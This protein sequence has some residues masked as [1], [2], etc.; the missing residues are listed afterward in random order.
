MSNDNYSAERSIANYRIN[1]A[2]EHLLGL[3]TGLVADGQLNDIE[4]KMLSLWIT[5][6]PE[7]ASEYPGSV[8]VKKITEVLVDGIITEE[9]RTHLLT[10]LLQ[11]ASADFSSTGSAD[12]EVVA[13]PIDDNVSPDFRNSTVCFTGNFLYGTKSD[14]LKLTEKFG[15]KCINSLTKKVNVLVIGTKVSPD[16]KHTTFGNKIKNAAEL[17]S[18]GHRIHIISE[19]RWLELLR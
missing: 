18:S 4:I 3:V 15:A 1:R 11:L 17:Q 9:E 2:I 8:L 6:H 7:V 19:R 5:T 10:F 14:C 12:S 13:L 16:W